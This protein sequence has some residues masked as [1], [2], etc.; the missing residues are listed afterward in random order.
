MTT[1]TASPVAPPAGITAQR[2]EIFRTG[3]HKDT[4]Q[5]K[6]QWTTAHLDEM[7]AAYNSIAGHH[8]APAIADAPIQA[9]HGEAQPAY[10]WIAKAYREGDRLFADY[11]DV[12]STFANMVNAGNY[13]KRSISLYPP[14]HEDNPTP[15]RWNIRHVAYVPVPAVKGMGDHTFSHDAAGTLVFDF[16]EAEAKKPAETAKPADFGEN[17]CGAIATILGKQ[18]DALIAASGVEAANAVFPVELI[19]EI[20]EEAGRRYL[21]GSDLQPLYSEISFLR[22]MLSE[23]RNRPANLVPSYQ[24]NTD[25]PTSPATA[26]VIPATPENIPAPSAPTTVPATTPAVVPVPVTPAADPAVEARLAQMES[27]FSEVQA[28]LGSATAQIATLQ[29]ENEALKAINQQ[30]AFSVEAGRISNFVEGLVND[31]RITPEQKATKV[32]L[33][34][35]VSGDSTVDFG[36][37]V[38]LT[39]RQALMNDMKAGEPLW[40][41]S[42]LPTGRAHSPRRGSKTANFSAP[43]GYAID[44]ESAAAHDKAVSYCESQ[45]WDWR[46]ETRYTAALI[47]TL[48]D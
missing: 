43:D 29:A 46:D 15:G 2:V 23:L 28:T 30:Q 4:A 34:L 6:K 1:A 16:T 20:Q 8:D 39:P 44:S 24:E 48:D 36:E 32:K 40:S 27:N 5:S 9:G 26:P 37:G 18:R 13:R 7:A 17:K 21:D 47:A 35:S 25:M 42:P 19:A 10:G 38:V 31:H 22:E 45:Q 14:E 11:R 41:D 3:T 33:L 12:D